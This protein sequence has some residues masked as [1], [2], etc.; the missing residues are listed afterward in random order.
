VLRPFEELTRLR[1][2]RSAM[3]AAGRARGFLEAARQRP[4]A[5]RAALT[6]S[7]ENLEGLIMPFEEAQARLEYGR[8][9]RHIGQRR[10]AARELSAARSLF[11]ALG[12]RPFRDRCDSELGHDARSLPLDSQPPLT[13]RQLIVARAVASGK[14]NR[15]I[16]TELYISVKTVEFHVN[17][18]LMR[19]GVDSRAEVAMALAASRHPD[20]AVTC[21]GP[22][23]LTRPDGEK[24]R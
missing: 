1:A 5:A 22:G 2:R 8:F 17:Q 13:P 12:A 15:D 6:G 14:S 4:D 18:I 19:L 23:A 9:L 7:V 21:A 20:G 10:R 3:A 16:A 11:A 24:S